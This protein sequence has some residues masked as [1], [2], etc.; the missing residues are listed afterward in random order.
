MKLSITPR[1]RMAL[2]ASLMLG[3][4]QAHAAGTAAGTSVDNT[5]TVDFQ[6]GGV[7]QPQ[8]TSNT[9]SFLVDRRINLTV[10]EVGGAATVVVPGATSQVLTYTVTNNANSPLDFRLLATQ[11]AGGA[12]PFANGA[13]TNDNFDATNLQVF[14]ES[15]VTGGFQPLEDTATFID[16]LAADATITVYVV[17]DIPSARA[18]GDIAAVTLTA[19]AAQSVNG[20]G[21]YVATPGTLAADAAESNVGS[22]DNTA[23]IDTVFGDAAG[24][25]PDAAENGQHSDTDQYNVVTATIAVTKSSRVVS[26]P[27]NGTTNPKSIPGATIEYCLDVNNTGA[28]T[29]GSLVLTDAIPA[30]TTYVA[31]SIRSAVTGTGAACD[32]GFTTG[33]SEDD[34]TAGAD[35]GDPDGGDFGVTT[36][37]AVTVTTPSITTG[38]RFK[39]TFRVTVD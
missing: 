15:G 38:N 4:V 39:A 31:G 11:L 17:A 2:A 14:V 32:D 19:I 36:G 13:N 9:T 6:V 8:Q 34:D 37:G 26:D 22:A 24:D 35:E 21:A 18:N 28:A 27:F 29:A 25:S 3:T 5:F 33:T 10:A 7:A 12:A 1:F 16:E 30:N 23:F 20:T